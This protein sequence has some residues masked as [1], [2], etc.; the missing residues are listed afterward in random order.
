MSETPKKYIQ[1]LDQ[2]IPL[3][4]AA[5]AWFKIWIYVLIF[6]IFATIALSGVFY[7]ISKEDQRAKQSLQAF[8]VE[9]PRAGEELPLGKS[10][11][12]MLEGR[13]PVVETSDPANAADV[14]VEVYRLPDRE[15]VRQTGRARISAV[16]GHW[17]FESALFAGNGDYEI[18]VAGSLGARKVFRY[19]K[20][21]CRDKA[22]V[23]RSAIDTDRQLRGVPVLS[24][25]KPAAPSLPTVQ[26]QL[27]Q[28]QE[29][30]WR[31][32]PRDPDAALKVVFAGF[33]IVDQALPE[34][35][36]D[37]QLQNFRAYMLKNYAMI[38]RDKTRP[39]EFNR[40]LDESAK[41]FEAIRQ[42]EPGD[43]AAWNGLG[44]LELL[45]EN[46]HRALI[47]ID[48]ALELMPN[49][50]AALNDRALALEM[51]RAAAD[52]KK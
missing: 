1:F 16:E 30:F 23:Y 4:E 21:T 11:S 24:A 10:L 5:P 12:W 44:S 26:Q 14:R 34:F 38:M 27:F 37:Y 36:N 25:A 29:E 19:V 3:L 39:A 49:Y 32:Y 35:P 13:F 7:L 42:Q 50:P 18:V 48:R 9:R 15:E 51:I 45:R 31:H 20:V 22:D 46:P 33:D 41:M 8:S 43:A 40:A 47:Y 17:R 6:L 28:N 2:L 52:A